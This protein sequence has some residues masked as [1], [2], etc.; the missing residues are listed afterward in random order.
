MMSTMMTETSDSEYAQDIISY[1]REQRTGIDLHNLVAITMLEYNLSINDAVTRSS[2]QH[3]DLRHR[4]LM[5]YRSIDSE[6]QG[7]AATNE[8]LRE[9]LRNL[10][11][12]PHGIYCWHFECGRYFGDKGAEI[13]VSRTVE[14]QPRVCTSE[15]R[16]QE[17][18]ALLEMDDV[19]VI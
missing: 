4:F 17:N 11:H 19:R 5:A 12:F 10:A 6:P 13:S 8:Q 2:K 9:A 7:D 14:I 18:V 3:E 1:N 16:W 15:T